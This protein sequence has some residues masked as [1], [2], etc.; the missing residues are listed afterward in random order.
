[1]KLFFG[2]FCIFSGAA[3]AVSFRECITLGSPPDAHQD[4]I[5]LIM[6][7]YIT[8]PG[9]NSSHRKVD[10]WKTF[11]FPF[12]MAQPRRCE[13]LVSWSVSLNLTYQVI[14]CDL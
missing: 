8:P 1:M 4:D 6:L 13:L 11:S 3:C 9:T 12:W 7:N 10:G 5:T 14:P 2:V